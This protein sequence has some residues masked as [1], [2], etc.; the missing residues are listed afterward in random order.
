MGNVLYANV[1]QTLVE[2]I[3]FNTILKRLFYKY[4]L[5]K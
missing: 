3:Y 2:D 1:M 4:D 5:N